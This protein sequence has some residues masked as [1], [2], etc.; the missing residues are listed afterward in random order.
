MATTYSTTAKVKAKLEIA[1]GDAAYDT[2]IDD[3]RDAAYAWINQKLRNYTDV[4]L[5]DTVE[6]YDVIVEAERLIAAGS[7]RHGKEEPKDDRGAS[8]NWGKSLKKE[9]ENKVLEYINDHFALGED[10]SETYLAHNRSSDS[11]EED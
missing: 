11:W 1:S 2:E 4:P 10:T 3:L 8:I 5:A 7:F 9:G 6:D